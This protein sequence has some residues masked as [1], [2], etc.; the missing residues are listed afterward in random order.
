MSRL[1][2]LLVALA[3]ILPSA[4]QSAQGIYADHDSPHDYRLVFRSGT[5]VKQHAA[6]SGILTLDSGREVWVS[7]DAQNGELAS[8]AANRWAEALNARRSGLAEASSNTLVL[9]RIL[10]IELRGALRGVKLKDLGESL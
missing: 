5:Y 1:L 6:F 3:A 8:S 7:L 2:L 10:R 4:C 9:R